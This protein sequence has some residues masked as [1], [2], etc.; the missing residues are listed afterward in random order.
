MFTP[1]VDDS[2]VYHHTGTSLSIID[3]ATGTVSAT[4][5]DPAGATSTGY[6]YHGSPV[7]GGRNNVLAFAKNAFSGRA[8]SNVEQYDQRVISSFNRNTRRY[9]W[10]TTNTYL[11]APAVSDGVISFPAAA[12]CI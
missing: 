8:S 2:H 7:I 4:I 6:S 1:A 10:S 12:P 11:T 9:E 5:A 3:R